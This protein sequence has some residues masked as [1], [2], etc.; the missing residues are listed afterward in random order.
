LIF[1]Y[2]LQGVLEV[3]FGSAIVLQ[4]SEEGKGLDPKIR[5]V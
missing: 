5:E 3:L 2:D 4:V 1:A